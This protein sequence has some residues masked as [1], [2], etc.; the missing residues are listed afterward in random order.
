MTRPPRSPPWPIGSSSDRLPLPSAS[1]SPPILITPPAPPCSP[2]SPWPAVASRSSPI[3]RPRPAPANAA[4][5][6]AM[7]CAS[8]SA[9]PPA[10]PAPSSCPKSLPANGQIVGC[11]GCV[12]LVKAPQE[13]FRLQV[14]RALLVGVFSAAGGPGFCPGRIRWRLRGRPPFPVEQY[15][16]IMN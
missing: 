1:G 2:A 3:P 4:S 6:S 7:P 13:L 15:R 12:G 16:C 10:A 14:V 9:A 8:A 5:S 11:R